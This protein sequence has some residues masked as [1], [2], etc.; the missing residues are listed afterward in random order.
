MG[1]ERTDWAKEATLLRPAKLTLALYQSAPALEA[2]RPW[3]PDHLLPLYGGE[4]F[5]SLTAS[6]RLRYNHAYARQL[7]HEFIWTERGLI[8]APLKQLCR[9]RALDSDQSAVLAS[10]MSDEMHHIESFTHLESLA[11][12]ADQPANESM[13]RPP[14]LLRVLLSLAQRYPTTLTFWAPVIEAFE[15]HALKIAQEYHRD[16]SIDPLFREVF[17]AH[18]RDEARHCRFDALIASW[19]QDGA[20][21][22]SK[23][24][25][26]TLLATFTSVYR[27][28]EWGLDGALVDLARSHPE[29]AGKLPQLLAEAKALRRAAPLPV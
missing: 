4:A 1:I 12:A 18:A 14:R 10:F 22:I 25:N 2:S 24:V 16:E 19:L 9:T 13:F 27:S 29:L 20:G 6:Q 3:V 23:A 7:V 11:V 15:K 28:V 17:V 8:L 21:A 5:A 26:S